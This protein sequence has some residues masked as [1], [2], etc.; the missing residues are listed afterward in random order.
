MPPLGLH[1]TAAKRIAAELQSR[2]IDAERGAYY[3]GSTTPDIRVLTRW[4]R[5]RTHFFRLDEFGEQ[6]GVH[7]LF[8]QEPALRDASNLNAATGAFVA[9]YISHLVFD[10]S[11]ITQ[12]YRPVF[13]EQSCLGDNVKANLM[14]R[15]LQF[16]MDRRERSDRATIEEIQRELAE[17]AVEVSVE[18]VDRETLLR[19]RDMSVDILHPHSKER[20]EKMF[21]RHLAAIGIEGDELVAAFMEDEAPELLHETIDVVGKERI[22]SYLESA[23]EQARR[24]MKEYLL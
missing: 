11:Y 13:G 2:V 8:E 18:F 12:V 17:S 5:E 19:W 9:G 22:R 15:L 21:V 14:D 10:E 20:L 3:L 6:S 1:M 23:R 24:A 7:R 4:D 16:E